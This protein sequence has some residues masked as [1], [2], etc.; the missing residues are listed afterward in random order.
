MLISIFIGLKLAKN[1]MKIGVKEKIFREF[2]Y[3]WVKLL[4]I[5]GKFSMLETYFYSKENT[6]RK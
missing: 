6:E 5:V 2:G 1:V 4:T 3:L